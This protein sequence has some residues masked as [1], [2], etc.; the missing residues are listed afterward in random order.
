MAETKK[1]NQLKNYTTPHT[2]LHT[3]ILTGYV[4]KS[5]ILSGRLYFIKPPKIILRTK[6]IFP[7][8]YEIDKL[9]VAQSHA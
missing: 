6:A 5:G 9:C 8:Q 3:N 1:Y 4:T 2:M 7:K